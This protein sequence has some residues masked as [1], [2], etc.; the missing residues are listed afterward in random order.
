MKFLHE[1]PS[2]EDTH[3][4]MN[5]HDN[6]RMLLACNNKLQTVASVGSGK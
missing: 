4:E 2:L 3:A 5:Y 1:N 6:E